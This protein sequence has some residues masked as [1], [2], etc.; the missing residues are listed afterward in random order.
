[1]CIYLLTLTFTNSDYHIANEQRD[2]QSIACSD[3]DVSIRRWQKQSDHLIDTR[4]RLRRGSFA[5]RKPLQQRVWVQFCSDS[6]VQ[7]GDCS[8]YLIPKYLQQETSRLWSETRSRPQLER[9]FEPRRDITPTSASKSAWWNLDSDCSLVPRR[10]YTELFKH[11]HTHTHTHTHSAESGWHSWRGVHTA[12]GAKC[13]GEERK[14]AGS[15]FSWR[16]LKGR[17]IFWFFLSLPHTHTDTHTHTHYFQLI[18]MQTNT[19]CTHRNS[20]G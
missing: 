6:V 14:N 15:L 3:C 20:S 18:C 9:R 8:F 7:V 17:S 5:V 11:T 1:M 13:G 2:D 12:R 10:P 19:Q 16:D 4:S